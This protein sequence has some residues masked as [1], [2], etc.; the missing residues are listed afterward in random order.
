MRRV[1]I[2]RLKITDPIRDSRLKR[3]LK[4]SKTWDKE[5]RGFVLIVTT[6]RAFWALSYQPRGINPATGKRWGGGVRHELGDAFQTSASVARARALEAK[7]QV[8]LGR[9]PHREQMVAAAAQAAGRAHKPTTIGDALALYLQVIDRR[10][11]TSSA[12]KRKSAHYI[13]KALRFAKLELTAPLTALDVHAIRTMLV[14]L[15]DGE[16]EVFFVFAALKRLAAWARKR[17]LITGD[18]IADLDEDEAP[19][20]GRA[21]DHTP[22]IETLRRIWAAVESEPPHIRALVRFMLLT[23]LRRREAEGL[24]WDEIERGRLRIPAKR[25]KKGTHELPLS[26]ATLEIIAKRPQ[27]GDRVFAA[28][29]GAKSLNWTNLALRIRRAIGEQGRAKDERFSFHDFRRSFVS[30]LAE[31]GFDVD[32]LDQILGHARKGV[33]GV[34]QRAARMPE[35]ERALEAWAN[36]LLESNVV[37]FCARV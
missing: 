33:F 27:T 20:R 31:R 25:A 28:P 9:D 17:Q 10:S 29:S 14:S 7:A 37:T 23:P 32:L 4:P 12:T 35:R 13:R 5:V 8:R 16:H 22:S 2:P 24:L 34:Y 30:H 11:R 18:P 1:K 3:P 6:R 21:R 15:K 26:A 36:L 19:R